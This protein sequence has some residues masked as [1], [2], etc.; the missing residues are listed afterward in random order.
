MKQVYSE[1]HLFDGHFNNAAFVD[2][3]A[4]LPLTKQPGTF[5]RYG[6]ST[7]VLGRVI[8]VVSGETLYHFMKRRIFDPLG[9]VHT[10]FLIDA[11]EE[12]ALTAAPLQNDASLAYAESAFRTHPEW[13]SGAAGLFSTA[14]DYARFAQMLLNAVSSK[15]NA[16][17]LPLPSKT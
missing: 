13:E 11:P 5:W 7:D 9:M 12:L 10:K 8:E 4:E 17:F 2:R 15:A 3:I 14:S 16:I 6:H 1:A